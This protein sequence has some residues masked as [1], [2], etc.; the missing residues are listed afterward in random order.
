MQGDVRREG[1]RGGEGWGGVGR[2]AR[3]RK[4]VREEKRVLTTAFCKLVTT[5]TTESLC[6]TSR[7]SL[8]TGLAKAEPTRGSAKRMRVKS[9]LRV[10][11]SKNEL[12]S[13]AELSAKGNV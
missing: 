1:V 2:G 9:M 11:T 6:T 8:M 4:M 12:K 3:E 13:S 5:V 10:R 7:E